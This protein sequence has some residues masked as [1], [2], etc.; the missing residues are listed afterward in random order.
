MPSFGSNTV[1]SLVLPPEHEAEPCKELRSHLFLV[2][3]QCAQYQ[4]RYYCLVYETSVNQDDN[5]TTVP[6]TVTVAKEKKIIVGI[7]IVMSLFF[8]TPGAFT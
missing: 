1:K 3:F 4:C 2:H 5:S 8:Y 6:P 7:K